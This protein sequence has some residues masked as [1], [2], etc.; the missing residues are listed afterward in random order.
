MLVVTSAIETVAVCAGGCGDGGSEE[1][2][3]LGVMMIAN[4]VA[5]SRGGTVPDGVEPLNQLQL[6][7]AMRDDVV[8]A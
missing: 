3:A 2:G 7:P 4:V 8:A 1:A 6:E 5:A